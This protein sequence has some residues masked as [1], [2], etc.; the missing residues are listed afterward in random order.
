VAD[1]EE[2]NNHNE[3]HMVV[4]NICVLLENNEKKTIKQTEMGQPGNRYPQIALE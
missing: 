4:D 1:A 2:Q 3:T